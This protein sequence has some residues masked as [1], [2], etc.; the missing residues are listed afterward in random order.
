MTEQSNKTLST[1]Y[2][3]LQP[4]YQIIK[5]ANDMGMQIGTLIA[6]K[7]TEGDEN[8]PFRIETH[9]FPVV[10]YENKSVAPLEKNLFHHDYMEG[11]VWNRVEL[12]DIS[13]VCLSNSHLTWPEYI[14]FLW[15]DIHRSSHTTV[16]QLLTF[17]K[18]SSFGVTIDLPSPGQ[19]LLNLS[20]YHQDSPEMIRTSEQDLLA[21]N[22]E[23]IDDEEKMMTVIENQL[24]TYLAYL[25]PRRSTRKWTI[26]FATSEEDLIP[27]VDKLNANDRI[28]GFGSSRAG[29]FFTIHAVKPYKKLDD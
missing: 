9:S 23:K 25:S 28:T 3:P 12:R 4:P 7:Q 29:S 17:S 20:T 10:A 16:P 1:T 24:F 19:I 26:K 21:L 8:N 13:T 2:V 18:L 5:Y 14:S 15:R 6:T 22:F 27:F 11:V